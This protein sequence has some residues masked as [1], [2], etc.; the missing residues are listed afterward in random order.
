MGMSIVAV[1][2]MPIRLYLARRAYRKIAR[3]VAAANGKTP[4]I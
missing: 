4:R 2:I 3:A 1:M